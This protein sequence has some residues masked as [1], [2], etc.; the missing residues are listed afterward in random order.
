MQPLISSCL[1]ITA[2]ARLQSDVCVERARQVRRRRRGEEAAPIRTAQ[3]DYAPRSEHAMKLAQRLLRIGKMLEERMAEYP[4]EAAVLEGQ[5]IDVR[6]FEP[7]LPASFARRGLSRAGDLVGREIDPDDFARVDVRGESQGDR[8][9]AASAIEEP[10]ARAQVR[11]EE[12][13][14]GGE[15]S[16]CHEVRDR[17]GM[18]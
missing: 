8:A 12:R 14:V 17:S 7:H 18:A 5:R 10:Q 11:H 9:R 1:Y 15:R 16:P 2:I 3:P 6:G 13:S 4:L